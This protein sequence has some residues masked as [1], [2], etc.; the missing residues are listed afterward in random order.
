[1]KNSRSD[2]ETLEVRCCCVPEKLL[3]WIEVPINARNIR[4]AFAPP[5][6]PIFGEDMDMVFGASKNVDLPIEKIN[7]DGRQ[8]RAIKAEGLEKKDLMRFPGFKPNG[9]P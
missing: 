3:G 4:L 6:H 5:M 7:I 1:M 8:Y 2:Y 9:L